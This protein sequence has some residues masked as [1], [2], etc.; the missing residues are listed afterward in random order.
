MKGVKQP[1]SGQG[2]NETLDH[3]K[4]KTA[5]GSFRH[6]SLKKVTRLPCKDRRKVL[7]ILKKNVRR[8]SGRDRTNRSCEVKSL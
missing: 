5:V 7:K 3:T 2:K 6:L 8:R 1:G 4:R